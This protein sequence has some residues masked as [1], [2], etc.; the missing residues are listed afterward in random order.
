VEGGADDVDDD[1]ALSP[2]VELPVVL[3]RISSYMVI[4]SV[5]TFPRHVI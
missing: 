1:A 2:G 3:V 4:I 5:A